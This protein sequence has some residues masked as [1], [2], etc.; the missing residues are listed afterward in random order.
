MILLDTN[1]VSELMAREPNK[2]VIDWLNSI[3]TNNLSFS[4]V[5]IGEISYGL[6][7]MSQ[8][9]RKSFLI[10]RFEYFLE[11]VFAERIFNFDESSALLYG[12]LMAKRRKKGKPMASLDGQIAAIAID[13]KLSLATRNSKD[14]INLGL[15]LINPFS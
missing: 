8:S 15:E 3:P 7:T 13:K 9:K 2:K 4:T 10:N 1:I 5:S 12:E 11:K 14:F 6:E